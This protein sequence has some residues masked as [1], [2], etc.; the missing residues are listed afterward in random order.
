MF[1]VGTNQRKLV[2]PELQIAAFQ[3]RVGVFGVIHNRKKVRISEP[4]AEQLPVD[5]KN[6]DQRFRLALSGRIAELQNHGHK[7]ANSRDQRQNGDNG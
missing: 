5:V 1:E 2:Q 3:D 4:K 6:L 7:P